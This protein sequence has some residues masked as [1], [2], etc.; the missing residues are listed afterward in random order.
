MRSR[1]ANF[2][3]STWLARMAASSSSRSAK[4]GTFF[5][6]SGWQDMADLAAVEIRISGK[7]KDSIKRLAMTKRGEKGEKGLASDRRGAGRP[8]D[9]RQDEI[10]ETVDAAFW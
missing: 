1:G 7:G 4:R 5:S 10:E 3:S 9:G 2:F 6:D 8:G